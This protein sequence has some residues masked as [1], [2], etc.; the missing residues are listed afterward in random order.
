MPGPTAQVW[1]LVSAA[2]G[3]RGGRSPVRGAGEAASAGWEEGSGRE[4]PGMRKLRPRRARGLPL[5][6]RPPQLSFH[7]TG[8]RRKRG[9]GST[10]EWSLW[11]FCYHHSAWSLWPRRNDYLSPQ[12]L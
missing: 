7:N 11:A 4:Q 12:Q 6:P 10:E 5:A 8:W 3:P 9:M 2:Q 1:T